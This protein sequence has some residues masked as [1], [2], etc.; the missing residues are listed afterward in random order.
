M[1]KPSL[2][3]KV[4]EGFLIG[5]FWDCRRLDLKPVEELARVFES[6]LAHGGH[7]ELVID[8]SG[9]E[10]AGST[11]LG[12]LLRMQ[13]MAV[14]RGGLVILCRVDPSV[15]EPFLAVRVEGLFRFVA[16]LEDALAL[17]RERAAARKARGQ[18][19]ANPG[20]AR[21]GLSTITRR[22]GPLRR[23]RRQVNSNPEPGDQSPEGVS[24]GEE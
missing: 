24:S 23:A 14:S 2:Q 19:G 16:E 10:Y 1:L 20:R 22:A 17:A 8:L 11:V 9:V 18:D 5:E 4:E 21:Q 3:T 15:R 6:H 12:T 7:P 13:K